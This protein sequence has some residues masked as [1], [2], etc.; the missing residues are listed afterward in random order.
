[1]KS[2]EQLEEGCGI[3]I[4]PHLKVKMPCGEIGGGKQIYCEECE[5]RIYTLKEVLKLIDE[6]LL[7]V[8]TKLNMSPRLP[9]MTQSNL[10]GMILALEELKQEIKGAKGK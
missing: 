10:S 5:A 2:I 3:E 7:E 4:Q 9:E 6:R 1:M 8:S